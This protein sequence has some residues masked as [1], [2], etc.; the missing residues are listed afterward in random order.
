MSHDFERSWVIEQQRRP[1]G[2]D[3]VSNDAIDASDRPDQSAHGRAKRPRV[4]QPQRVCLDAHCH[5]RPTK[6]GSSASSMNEER[7]RDRISFDGIRDRTERRDDVHFVPT[8]RQRSRLGADEVSR[9]IIIVRRVRSRDE[10]EFQRQSPV[11]HLESGVS[12]RLRRSSPQTPC[13]STFELWLWTNEERRAARGTGAMVVR[14]PLCSTR[15]PAF[16]R[17]GQTSIYCTTSIFD[18]LRRRRAASDAFLRRLTEG[19]M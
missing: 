11:A 3:P 15:G 7:W 10:E 16:Q 13:S 4:E 2:N 18:R 12:N 19:F 1:R 5:A 17:W 8:P 14:Q 6:E 9:R